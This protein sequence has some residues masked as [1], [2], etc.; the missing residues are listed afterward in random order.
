MIHLRYDEKVLVYRL[1][2]MD[3]GDLDIIPSC[4]QDKGISRLAWGKYYLWSVRIPPTG[5]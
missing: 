2:C 4:S 1:G 5:Y 3:G